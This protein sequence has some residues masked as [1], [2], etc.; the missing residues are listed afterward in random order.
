MLA[1]TTI[2]SSIHFAAKR[3]L[4]LLI[5]SY[6]LASKNTSWRSPVFAGQVVIPEVSQTRSIFPVGIA[7]AAS[8]NPLARQPVASTADLQVVAHK[9]PLSKQIHSFVYTFA[10]SS[11]AQLTIIL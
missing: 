11:A 7:G 8:L 9:N 6:K 1:S 10:S 3:H 2:P 4:L 5:G